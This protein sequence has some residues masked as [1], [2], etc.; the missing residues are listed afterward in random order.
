MNSIVDFAMTH[1]GLEISVTLQP[2]VEQLHLKLRDSNTGRI[3][4]WAVDPKLM[5]HADDRWRD[6]TED[7]LRHLYGKIRYDTIEAILT[8]GDPWQHPTTS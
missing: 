5:K 2:S 4:S 3:I 1:P 6:R 7:I 8:E